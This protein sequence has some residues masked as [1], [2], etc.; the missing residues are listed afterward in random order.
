MYHICYL[1]KCNIQ[2]KAVSMGS[3]A[4]IQNWR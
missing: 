4:G 3:Q 1:K 2:N